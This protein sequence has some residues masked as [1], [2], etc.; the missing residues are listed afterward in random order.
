LK[1]DD[2]LAAKAQQYADRLV[3][4][5]SGLSDVA[6]IHENPDQGLGE[7]IY[8]GDNSEKQTCV[9]ASLSWYVCQYSCVSIGFITV[10][11]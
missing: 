6:L 9:D 8:W 10:I 3:E 11:S 4:I 7:N 5:N 1:W 2:S